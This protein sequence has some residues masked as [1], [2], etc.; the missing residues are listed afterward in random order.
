MASVGRQGP[1]TSTRGTESAMQQDEVYCQHNDAIGPGVGGGQGPQHTEH[2]NIEKNVAAS[3]AFAPTRRSEGV[4]LDHPQLFTSLGHGSGPKSFFVADLCNNSTFSEGIG[5]KPPKQAPTLVDLETGPRSAGLGL[6]NMM[7]LGLE[8]EVIGL[9]QK[10]LTFDIISPEHEE[11]KGIVGC[12]G[13]F[14]IIQQGG[15]MRED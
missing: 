5:P 1:P 13:G 4:P 11:Q 9:K 6:E 3:A 8:P 12:I 7:D 2:I 14:G 10:V 15:R